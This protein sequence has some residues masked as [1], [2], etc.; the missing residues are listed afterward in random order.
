MGADDRP[1]GP[2]T[3]LVTGASGGVGRGIAL[4]CGAVGWQV[5]IA[6]RRAAEA[7]KVAAE[8]TAAGGEGRSVVCDVGDEDSVRAAIDA[9]SAAA[10]RLDGVVHNATSG[11][12]SHVGVDDRRDGR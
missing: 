4:A 11:R 12:S 8:V 2:R 7:A 6:A 5:W 9:I 1:S 3:V 10:G